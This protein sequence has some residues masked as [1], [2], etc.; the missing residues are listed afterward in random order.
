MAEA[1]AR[2]LCNLTGLYFDKSESIYKEIV[3]NVKQ[4]DNPRAAADLEKAHST[5]LNIPSEQFPLLE[6]NSETLK[7]SIKQCREAA[8]SL[9]ALMSEREKLVSNHK[10]AL[11][12]YEK[13]SANKRQEFRQDMET[14]LNEF[15]AAYKA[16]LKVLATAP[17]AVSDGAA[18]HD[19]EST[20]SSTTAPAMQTEAEV[21]NAHS[22]STDD[23]SSEEESDSEVSS[24]D[25]SESEPE[26]DSQDESEQESDSDVD[27]ESS[28]D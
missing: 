16:R 24:D 12:E 4:F 27:S 25:E 9:R 17:A 2:E 26:S 7:L 6:A 15:N 28:D 22:D 18:N 10:L 14:K 5:T 8:E 23:D 19:E 13:A 21:S 11:D 1:V 20:S 3:Q